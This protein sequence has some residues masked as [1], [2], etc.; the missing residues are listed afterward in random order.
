MDEKKP[1]KKSKV[2]RKRADRFLKVDAWLWNFFH[3]TAGDPALI[4]KDYF[5]KVYKKEKTDGRKKS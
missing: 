4:D 2:E 1:K 3:S 5:N